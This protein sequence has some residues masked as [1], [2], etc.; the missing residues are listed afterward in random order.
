MSLVSRLKKA[1]VK[2][3]VSN[4]KNPIWK[5]P[6]ESGITQSL[7]SKFL[8]CRERFRLYVVE[9]L[10]TQDRFNHRMGYGDMWHLCEEHYAKG[11]DWQTPLRDFAKSLI[12]RFKQ[13]QTEIVHW[14]EVC[15]TQF[16]IYVKHWKSYRLKNL[17]KT[18]H[19]EHVFNVKYK[20]PSSRIV[21]LRGKFDSVFKSPEGKYFLQ[22]NKTKGD[23]EESVIDR[24]LRGDLQTMLYLVALREI[25]KTVPS[26]ILYNVVR[27]PLSGGK[28]SIRKH[29][30]TKSNPAGESDAEFYGR[31]STIIE[32][33]KDYFFM[34]RES[35]VSGKDIELFE[36]RSLIPILETLCDWWEDLNKA[37]SPFESHSHYVL[38]YG[39]SS[40]LI[41]GGFSDLDEYL[42]NGNETGLQ[43]VKTIFPELV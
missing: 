36:E 3:R 40:P 18:T 41:D 43:R 19:S 28:G 25:T 10:T 13:Q 14:Y 8:I 6:E 38:P 32:E 1:G 12:Q 26:G 22:E 11:E 4:H 27:R 29:Q 37:A 5:G 7:L 34:R 2:K 15:K 33:N 23:I 16:P 31:L 39:V 20:L 35:K 42:M 21:T 24:Q 30:P 17:K 9:G